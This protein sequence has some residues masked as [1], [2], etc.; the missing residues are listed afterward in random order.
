MPVSSMTVRLSIA[1]PDVLPARENLSNWPRDNA[2]RLKEVEFDGER[3]GGRV[4]RG[5]ASAV[6]VAPARPWA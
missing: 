4:V 6:S 1:K 5:R 2:L 3:S